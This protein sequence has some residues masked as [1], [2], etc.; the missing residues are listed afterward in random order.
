LQRGHKSVII[1]KNNYKTMGGPE[2]RDDDWVSKDELFVDE[3]EPFVTHTS[4]PDTKPKKAA[5]KKTTISPIAID[6]AILGVDEKFGENPPTAKEQ[7]KIAKTLK[8]SFPATVI[9]RRLAA[10]KKIALRSSWT[11]P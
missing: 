4:S 6:N 5:R 10:I 3:D 1:N 9:K 8:R 7:K 11:R 2:K